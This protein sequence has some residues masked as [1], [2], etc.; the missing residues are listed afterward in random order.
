MLHFVKLCKVSTKPIKLKS[1]FSPE[2]LPD[3]LLVAD[4][5]PDGGE[6]LEQVEVEVVGAGEHPL[7]RR[8]P[9][10]AEAQVVSPRD[11]QRF[12]ADGGRLGLG[13]LFLHA[14]AVYTLLLS[15]QI[16]N[17]IQ[18]VSHKMKWYW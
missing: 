11:E 18:I 8:V 1:V 13:E 16:V 12:V 2:F 7:V 17:K 15:T 14:R 10:L 4:A 6:P 5:V 3:Q 9:A